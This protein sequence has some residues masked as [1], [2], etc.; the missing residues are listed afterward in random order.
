MIWIHNLHLFLAPMY[1]KRLDLETNIG[2]SL[3]VPFPSS[4]IFRQFRHCQDIL[5]SLLCCDVVSFHVFEYARNFM[6]LSESLLRIEITRKK[7][8]FIVMEYNGNNILIKVNHIGMDFNEIKLMMQSQKCIEF[9]HQL[10]K[11]THTRKDKKYIIGSCDRWHPISGTLNKLQGYYNFLQNNP[12]YR[13]RVCLIQYLLP[14]DN[15]LM[16]N[17][18]ESR[19]SKYAKTYNRV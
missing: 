17:E 9:Q 13:S 12:V 16:S 18:L 6:A 10:T 1:L 8:G 3:H 7:G 15:Q 2:F 5:K 14:M 11:F 4:E 19:H